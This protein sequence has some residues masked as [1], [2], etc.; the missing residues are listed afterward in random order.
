MTLSVAFHPTLGNN[1]DSGD[2]TR[3]WPWLWP[4]VLSSQHFPLCLTFSRHSLALG[5]TLL[6]CCCV[7]HY[8]K[9][10]LKQKPYIISQSFRGSGTWG[11]LRWVVGAPD[12]SRDYS[13]DGSWGCR[14][15]RRLDGLEDLLPNT[16]SWLLVGGLGSSPHEPLHWEA[17]NMAFPRVRSNS[18][19]EH[20]RKP[21]HRPFVT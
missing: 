4:S 21:Q 10:W 20:S 3:P 19:K 1:Q 7:T 2:P 17:P 16:L 11:W 14:Q 8:P 18:E 15:Q 13:R 6:S 9:L 12:L 5:S